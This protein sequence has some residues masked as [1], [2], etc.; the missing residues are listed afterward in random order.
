MLAKPV[1]VT[2][3][4]AD[5]VRPL[6]VIPVMLYLD[7]GVALVLDPRVTPEAVREHIAAGVWSFTAGRALT[8]TTRLEGVPAHPVGPVGVK[9]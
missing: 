6:R 1:P 4:P 3:P 5:A 8:V 7:T 9:T 2:G